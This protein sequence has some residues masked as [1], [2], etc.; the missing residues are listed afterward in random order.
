[1]RKP[2]VDL[3]PLA[4]LLCS[5]CL[6]AFLALN[7]AGPP[8]C[9]VGAEE[10]I[11]CARGFETRE[12]DGRSFRWTDAAA[13]VRLHA[14]GYSAPLL[15]RIEL[16]ALRPAE[17]PPPRVDLALGRAQASFAAAPQPR[18]YLLLLEPAFPA[19]D[20]ATLTVASE[21]WRP[22]R[23]RRDLGVQVYDVTARPLG[24]P[25]L[26]GPLQ[27]L[28][29]LGIGLAAAL[30]SATHPT[31]AAQAQRSAP[32]YS[33][34]PLVA[35][36]AALVLAASLW[37]L[38]PARVAPFLPWLAL[39]LGGLALAWARWLPHRARAD[40]AAAIPLA[41]AV[42]AGAALDAAI[43]TDAARGAWRSAAVLAQGAAT[44]AALWWVC[45]RRASATAPALT[46]PVALGVAFAVRLLA[47]G[48]R[49]VAGAAAGD[50][51]VELFYS[52]GRATI[53]LGT[54][55]VEY[56]SGALVA[57]AL[58]ALPGS[59]ELFALLLPLFNTACDML[60]VWALWQIGAHSAQ[61]ADREGG[62]ASFD[63]Q[64]AL[65]L[66]YALSPLLVPFWHGKYDPLPAALLALGLAAFAA[67]RP[68]RSGALLGFGGAVK[69]VP[70]LA[71]PL[72]A[73]HYLRARRTGTPVAEAA[74]FTAGLI[75]A[76]ALASL[77]FA[78]HN[79][80]AFL[81]PYTLQGG[82]PLIGESLWFLPALI[83]EP[84]LL[85][86]LVSP[87]SNVESAVISPGL[88][89]AAQ[90]LALAALGLALLLAPPHARRT[91][92]L[93]ALAP[94]A[95]LL[96]NRI[97]SPQYVLLITVSALAAGAATL[98]GRDA[99]ALLSLLTVAQA[100][101]LL[102]WPYTSRLWLAAS[103]ALFASGLAALIWLAL[104]AALPRPA[105]LQLQRE[106]R[107]AGGHRELK[108]E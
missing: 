54:P 30:L 26:P 40:G 45:F 14:A 22:P 17:A 95:F 1:M 24:G 75:A 91:L 104:R 101:N 76:V 56:P 7:L 64:P 47:L 80:A 6:A 103:A 63:L 98:R 37:A 2:V 107:D 16:A 90:G 12:R 53:E 32:R 105:P 19:G 52:Y 57:W 55:V 72:L 66:F 74:R 41:L 93:A 87:W 50:P 35:G 5:A 21:T 13:Q 84:G 59:R 79:P 38:L 42:L 97:F 39:L 18:H 31:G 49:V 94:A 68:A 106:Q 77:P 11:G 8:R 28:A 27:V 82:R 96:L 48:V 81:A 102:V 44:L 99:L 25:R 62:A 36:L 10:D 88:T 34:P 3:L 83:A 46:L 78:L 33:A 61:P 73:L 100:A 85:A 86:E 43:V 58:M 60:I 89:V 15:V 71:A 4:L 69:W 20:I 67:G 108:A 70:W 51:D 29:L 92:A 65:P 23:D 9:D